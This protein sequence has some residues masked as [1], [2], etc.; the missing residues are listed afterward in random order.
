M[1]ATTLM[2]ILLAWTGAGLLAAIVFGRMI[3]E[4]DHA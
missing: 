3:Q 1:D 4:A 2:L